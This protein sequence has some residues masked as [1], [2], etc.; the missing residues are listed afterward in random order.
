[1]QSVSRQRVGKHISAYRT[2]LCNAVTSTIM[3]TVFSMV[4][5]QSAYKRTEIRSKLFQSSYELVLGRRIIS[6]PVRT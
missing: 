4:S 2:V 6:W 5:V 1:M 3:Q